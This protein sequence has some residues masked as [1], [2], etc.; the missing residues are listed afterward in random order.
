MTR[1]KHTQHARSHQCVV[2]CPGA[3]VSHT[4][5]LDPGKRTSNQQARPCTA[6]GP[7]VFTCVRVRVYMCVCV[8]ACLCVSLHRAL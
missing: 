7:A 4:G 5:V 1:D 6:H 3:V 8:C 2:G